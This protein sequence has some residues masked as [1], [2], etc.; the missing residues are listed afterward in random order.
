MLGGILLW[1]CGVFHS[2]RWVPRKA[3]WWFP[4]HV[5]AYILERLEG[6]RLGQ[7]GVMYLVAKGGLPLCLGYRLVSV[8]FWRPLF[9]F[10][11][12]LASIFPWVDVSSSGFFS[13]YWVLGQFC[14]RGCVWGFG[15]LLGGVFSTVPGDYCTG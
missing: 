4:S 8:P 5:V 6:L 3:A 13:L 15:D 7:S 14:G 9:L 1:F 12:R 11:P 2:G 10:L